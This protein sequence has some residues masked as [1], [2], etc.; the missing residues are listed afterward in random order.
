MKHSML[1]IEPSHTYKVV[2]SMAY[3]NG[4]SLAILTCYIRNTALF[5]VRKCARTLKNRTSIANYYD[6]TI[7][8]LSVPYQGVQIFGPPVW[9]SCKFL[10]QKLELWRSELPLLWPAPM[11]PTSPEL[12]DS[13]LSLPAFKSHLKTHL[14]KCL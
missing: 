1:T 2:K 11:E 10:T 13:R 9:A 7:F 12:R 5:F 4:R 3:N 8:F 6:H 14:F